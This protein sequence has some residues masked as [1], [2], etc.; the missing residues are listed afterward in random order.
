MENIIN[1]KEFR[2]NIGTYIEAVKSGK[3]FIVFKHSQ[4]LFRVAPLNKEELWEE[5]VDFTKIK[6]GGVEIKEILSRI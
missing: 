5:V 4:P 3:D 2:A 1:L 6:N